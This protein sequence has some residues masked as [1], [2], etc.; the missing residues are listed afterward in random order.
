MSMRSQVYEWDAGRGTTQVQRGQAGQRISIFIGGFGNN[1]TKPAETTA[2]E[3]VVIEDIA[4]TPSLSI[5]VNAQVA[6]NSTVRGLAFNSAM[7]TAGPRAYTQV[8]INTTDYFLNPDNV[9]NDGIPGTA[10][11][12]PRSINFQPSFN[13]YPDVYVL[14]GQ[15]WDVIVTFYNALGLLDTAGNQLTTVAVATNQLQCFVKYTL[16]DGP[17][18]LIANKLLEMGISINPGNVDWYKRSLLASQ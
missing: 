1:I 12:Y 6:A 9:P 14:P 18:A 4:V 5:G 10:S 16:Y 15:V 17:D 3:F 8:R 7:G 13:L 11:P 2:T